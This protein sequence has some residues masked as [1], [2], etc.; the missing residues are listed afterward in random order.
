MNL[1][2]ACDVRL[3]A[4]SARFDARFLE[5]GLH[6]GGGHTFLL[7]RAV[8]QQATRAMV[9]FGERLDAVEAE[10]RGLVWQCVDDDVLVDE[11][12]RLAS[13]AAKVPRDLLTTTK[14]TLRRSASLVDH[15]AAVDLEIV[16]Q[17]WSLGQP[18][19]A[20][21]LAALRSRISSSKPD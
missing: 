6:P 13:G 9:L 16:A 14:E 3:A 11:A 7:G 4:R 2:L 5:L 18:F 1:A 19:F 17:T 12:V 15:A 8:G 20:E 21:R 10:R